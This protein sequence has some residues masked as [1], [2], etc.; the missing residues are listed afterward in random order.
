MLIHNFRAGFATNSSSSHSVVLIPD[1][2]VGTV[3]DHDHDPNEYGWNEFIL[4]STESKMRYLA[5]QLLR[6]YLSYEETTYKEV[7]TEEAWMVIE[8]FDQ[9]IP[10]YRRE[11]ENYALVGEALP[12][13]VDH[14]SRMAVPKSYDK[15]FVNALIN[16]F[17]SP[18]VVVLGGNDNSDR[19]FRPI[20]GSVP[21]KL[22]AHLLGS[23]DR[24]CTL[25]VDGS[26]F[27]IFSQRTGDKM[28]FSMDTT[29]KPYEK[30]TTPELVDVKIT[31][32]CS[33]GCQFCYQ[34]STTKGQHAPL[35]VI[36]EIAQTLG[37]M[38]VFEVA[39]GGGEPTE[40][41]DFIEILKFFT[42][43]GV[44]PNFTTLSDRFLRD[45]EMRKAVMK[46][47]G[48]VG[49]SCLSAKD[50]DLV[51]EAK[52]AMPMWSGPRVLAQHV[53][54]SVPLD[55]TGEFLSKAFEE[56]I[57]VLLLGYKEVGFGKDYKRHDEGEVVTF[58]KLAV[59]RHDSVSLSV[60]TALVDRYPTLTKALGAPKALVT[61]P[62]GKFSC[63]IDA[64]ER[65]MGPSSYV[66]KSA[67]Q[68]LTLDVDAFKATFAK[69]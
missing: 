23:G 27:T 57:P 20:K 16:Y 14:Q 6:N 34:S 26:Y 53:L 65:R 62:E 63:Y 8:H 45:E 10:N 18:R 56:R 12:V 46:Y 31:D 29:A 32:Y 35:S 64:V 21:D 17:S 40:H 7:I 48:G 38:K 55:V 24:D 30:A 67:M 58:L 41:P 28:R 44:K 19:K 66:E 59:Q 5:A 61:S 50:L 47:V 22:G 43:A 60:D 42:A 3:T 68:P 52:K 33:K 11:M 54:G 49:I 36:K 39:I 1:A 51:R 25:R 37:A 9:V 69:W 13:G 4:A 15:D 2:M